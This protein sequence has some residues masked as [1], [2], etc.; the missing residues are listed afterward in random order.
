[1]HATLLADNSQHCW[2][3]LSVH[4]FAH[5]V[6]SCCVLLGVA[7]QSLKPVKLLSQQILDIFICSVIA[8]A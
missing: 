5:P 3:S 8:E 7:A 1:M 2:I 4:P 6:A